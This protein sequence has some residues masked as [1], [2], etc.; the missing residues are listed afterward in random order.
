MQNMAEKKVTFEFIKINDAYIHF[1][2]D[3]R[4]DFGNFSK[5]FACKP[6][7]L[8]KLANA[9]LTEGAGFSVSSF[10]HKNNTGIIALT[11]GNVK[12]EY[13]DD[14]FDSTVMFKKTLLKDFANEI[15]YLTEMEI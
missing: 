4:T 2:I 14:A 7:K 11:N 10:P 5:N 8:E 13:S 15:I 9:I 12:I 3:L 1:R 6:D